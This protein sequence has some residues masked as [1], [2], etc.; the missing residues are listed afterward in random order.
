M[1]CFPFPSQPSCLPPTP[2]K[3]AVLPLGAH[4]GATGPSAP[5]PFFGNFMCCR[6]KK[7]KRLDIFKHLPCVNFECGTPAK[8]GAII[9]ICARLGGG[10]RKGCGG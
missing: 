2:A 7:K 5:P 8:K 10:S 6:A 1:D 4:M 3:I 9:L